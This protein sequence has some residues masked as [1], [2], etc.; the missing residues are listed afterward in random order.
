MINSERVDKGD[1]FAP[2]VAEEAKGNQ[3]LI[4]DAVHQLREAIDRNIQADDILHKHIQ[5]VLSTEDAGG[6]RDVFAEPNSGSSLMIGAIR[7]LTDLVNFATSKKRSI[8][9]RVE[10]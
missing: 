8:T 3:E 5:P 4:K 2:S 6:P 9:E 1:D 10:L 7:E